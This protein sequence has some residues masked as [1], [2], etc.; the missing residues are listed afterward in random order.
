VRVTV[1]AAAESE[2]ADA[3]DYCNALRPG[4]GSAFVAE[5]R[6]AFARIEAYPDAWPPFSPAARRCLLDRFPYGVLYR[7]SGRDILVGAVMHLGRD[8]ARW[9]SRAGGLAGGG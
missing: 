6:R 7:V 1:T 9:A 3:V 4:L 2:L 8:P 5:V